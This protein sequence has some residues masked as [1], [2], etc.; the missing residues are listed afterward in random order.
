MAA[1]VLKLVCHHSPSYPDGYT[2]FDTFWVE[3]TFR[4]HTRWVSIPMGTE[5]RM[6]EPFSKG[7]SGAICPK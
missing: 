4:G 6:N 5:Y 1:E 7:T 3:E 2:S